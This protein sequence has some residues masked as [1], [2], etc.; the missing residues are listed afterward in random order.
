MNQ[1]DLS[2]KISC[3][4]WDNKRK[5]W[6][7]ADIVERGI[8]MQTDHGYEQAVGYLMAHDIPFDVIERALLNRLERRARTS[9]AL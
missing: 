5:D 8:E 3:A 9:G 2:E 4:E 6:V 7:S 1:Q